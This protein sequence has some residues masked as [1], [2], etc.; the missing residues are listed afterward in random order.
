MRFRLLCAFTVLFCPT[1]G[2]AASDRSVVNLFNGKDLNG[3]DSD[4]GP[5]ER[6]KSSLERNNDPL[7]VF[8]V[9]TEDGEPAIRVSG[10]VLGGLSTRREFVNYR[11]RLEFK[12]GKKRWPPREN[13]VRDSG[14]LYHCVGEPS[15]S[16]GWMQ[17]AE[18]NL[19]EQDCGDFWAVQGVKA[20]ADIIRMDSSDDLRRQFETWAKRNEGNYPPF[21]YRKGAPR[22][23]VHGEGLMKS[24]DAE[25]PTGQWNVVEVCCLGTTAVHVINGKPMMVLHNLR[26]PQGGKDVPLD[27][28][29]IQLQSE[30]AE[31][32]FR[33]LQV[34][35]IQQIPVEYAD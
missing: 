24:G 33:K 4:L 29:R 5:P 25:K 19:E 17:S 8:S 34:E 10:Q 14:I 3:W 1:V 22:M 16:T 6:G 9:V 11:L 7:R 31:I 2:Y 20:D 26:R 18:C 12:W 35:P 27:R 28:G 30:G 15:P 13:S 23:T 32:L 21:A